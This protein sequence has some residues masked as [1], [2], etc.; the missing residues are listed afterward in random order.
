MNDAQTVAAPRSAPRAAVEPL[1]LI[2]M[3]L[4]IVGGLAWLA[5]AG[6]ALIA[7]SVK[8]ADFPWFPT[9][10][11]GTSVSGLEWP[12]TVLTWGLTGLIGGTAI[13]WFG[14]ALIASMMGRKKKS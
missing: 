2:G 5:G 9:E 10:P 7:V 1:E 8:L 6:A 11:P 4:A 3:G 14:F 12:G 13:S